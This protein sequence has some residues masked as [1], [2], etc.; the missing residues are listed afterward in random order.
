MVRVVGDPC[1]VGAGGGGVVGGAVV[2]GRRRSRWSGWWSAA[3]R[4]RRLPPEHVPLSVHTSSGRGGWPGR[5]PGVHH[6]AVYLWPPSETCCPPCTPWSRPTPAPCSAPGGARGR[7]RTVGGVVGGVAPAN[8]V[9][10]FVKSHAPWATLLHVPDVVPLLSGGVHWR[11]RLTAQNVYRLRPWLG[12]V[13]QHVLEVGLGEDLAGVGPAVHLR[14]ALVV[15]RGRAAP[16]ERVHQHACGTPRA[17][18]SATPS[19]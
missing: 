18:R 3:G 15:V 12:R 13:V 11:S 1:R 10:N 4:G 9:V 14:H 16:A 17:P 8:C 6:L 5:R 7:R 19:R 2:G